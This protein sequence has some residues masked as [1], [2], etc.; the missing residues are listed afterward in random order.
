[1]LILVLG[2]GAIGV[3]VG[4]SV[5]GDVDCTGTV[6]ISDLVYL[7]GYMFGGGAAPQPCPA[8]PIPDSTY[9]DG[10]FKA[11][12]HTEVDSISGQIRRKV[13]AYWDGEPVD[14]F[15]YIDCRVLVVNSF[16]V[17]EWI[18]SLD[19]EGNK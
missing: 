12:V 13:I 6:N 5:P 10:L 15:E 2:G 18:D 3:A 16:K 9:T 1:M 11:Y 7:V 8:V 4:A 17:P 14:S 19:T